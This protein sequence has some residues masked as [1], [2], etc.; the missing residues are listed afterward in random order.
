[1][2]P[3]IAGLQVPL[4]S[5]CLEQSALSWAFQV[6]T[7]CV[8]SHSSKT[9]QQFQT[10]ISASVQWYIKV[11]PPLCTI[12]GEVPP[13]RKLVNLSSAPAEFHLLLGIMFLLCL[14]SS[15]VNNHMYLFI[16]IDD[17]GDDD[18]GLVFVDHSVVLFILETQA[19]QFKEVSLISSLMNASLS[20]SLFSLLGLP[21][22]GFWMSNIPKMFHYFS[23]TIP[24]LFLFSSTFW[25]IYLTSSSDLPFG[26]FIF[27]HHILNFQD[28]I[29]FS[30]NINVYSL[31]FFRFMRIIFTS[32]Q[33]VLM[34]YFKNVF[35]SCISSKLLFLLLVLSSCFKLE[36]LFS[37]LV[38]L[39]YPPMFT[40]RKLKVWLGTLCKRLG[41]FYYG[42][43]IW[44]C[45]LVELFLG[46]FSSTG[47]R[48]VLLSW[49][50]SSEKILLLS[51]EG[52]AVL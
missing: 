51:L 4:Y 11:L 21:V 31:L 20:F 23:L 47:F 32:C 50:E 15:V 13:D 46:S 2:S 30:L 45:V 24:F 27:C 17:H 25:E 28:Y 34:M 37:F 9:C 8:D 12:L 22:P 48:S 33:M 40:I 7:L 52:Q 39:N 5:L 18:V 41:L 43:H 10:S 42:C 6:L 26:L 3:N 38:I 19:L 49:S 36:D 29:F 44:V 16:F 35:D 14:L 1:M